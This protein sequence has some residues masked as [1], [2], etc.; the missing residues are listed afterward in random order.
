MTKSYTGKK[1]G[2]PNPYIATGELIDAVNL[3]LDLERPLLLEGEPGCGKT[4]LAANVAFEL[5][6]KYRPWLVRSSSK[7]QDGLYTYD[8]I[9]RLHDVHLDQHGRKPDKRDP[10]NPRDYRKFGPLGEAFEADQREVVLID[11]IDKADL[12][13]PNDLLAVLEKPRTFDIPYTGE[14]IT[15]K[16]PPLVIITSNKEKG[17]LPA[18]FLRRCVYYYLPFP[19]S[20]EGLFRIVAAHFPQQPQESEVR[21]W[22]RR[23]LKLRSATTLRRKPGTSE[24]IDWFTALFRNGKAAD[25]GPLPYPELLFKVR[26]DWQ[27][28][29]E[30]A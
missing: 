4:T 6:T 29:N 30:F 9:L 19:E 13:F 15:A 1:D 28:R 3:A 20:E 24:M 18:P 25:D 27:R 7:A 21:K 2:A 12:D 23:F 17:D 22:I 16:H 10:A 11:E 8:A 5:N 26:E 14:S